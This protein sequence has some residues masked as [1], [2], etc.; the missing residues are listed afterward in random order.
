MVF[1]ETVTELKQ[2]LPVTLALDSIA[3][4][5]SKL[6]G[7]F[8]TASVFC[9]VPTDVPTAPESR[10]DPVA[11]PGLAGETAAFGAA[12]GCSTGAMAA[13]TGDALVTGRAGVF[14]GTYMHC[15]EL[16]RMRSEFQRKR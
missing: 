9:A 16:L 1:S 6:P 8:G 2:G 3:T 5:E 4:A 12:G 14:V 7:A 15:S 13:F 11:L 10:G